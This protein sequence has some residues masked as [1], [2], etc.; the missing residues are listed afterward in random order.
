M[1]INAGAEVVMIFDSSAHLLKNDD[2][3]IYI[4]LIFDQLIEKFEKKIGYYAKDKVDYDHIVSVAKIKN[5]GLAGLGVDSNEPLSKY[6]RGKKNFFIQGNFNENFMLLP[7]SQMK[8]KLEEY[9]SSLL[10]FNEKE[11]AGWICGLGHGILKETPEENV[12]TFVKEIRE[13]FA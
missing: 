7:N 1:Q 9:I 4:N 11:R 2:F 13:A 8:L 5:F 3:K 10:K 6:F 12:K